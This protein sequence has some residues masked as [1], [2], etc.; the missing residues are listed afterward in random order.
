MALVADDVCLLRYDSEAG[1][2]DYNHVREREVP[3]HFTGLA[4]LHADF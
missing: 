1:T 4:T 2:G 3:Y